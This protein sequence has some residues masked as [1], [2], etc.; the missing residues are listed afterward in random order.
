RTGAAARARAAPEAP[1]MVSRSRATTTCRSASRC[2]SWPTRL[3]RAWASR[4]STGIIALVCPLVQSTLESEIQKLVQGELCTKPAAGV[5]PAGSSVD[6]GTGNCDYD[7]Q[8]GTC[9][10]IGLGLEG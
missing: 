2:R 4:S 1:P 9:L 10:P 8:P 5:C 7:V 3:P 6:T